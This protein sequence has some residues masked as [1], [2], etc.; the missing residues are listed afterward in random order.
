MK[1]VL[2]SVRKFI[3]AAAIVSSETTSMAVLY[4]PKKPAVL[5]KQKR[6]NEKKK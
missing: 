1:F 4:Q 6:T 2:N 5:V 3:K